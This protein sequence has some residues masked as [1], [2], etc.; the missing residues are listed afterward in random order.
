MKT[1]VVLVDRTIRMALGMLLV[2][3]PLLELPTYP[4]NLLGVV[5]VATA[6]IGYCPLYGFFTLFTAPRGV[7]SSVSNTAVALRSRG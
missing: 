4:F 6:V 3:S 7:K 5:L 1:N 2:S